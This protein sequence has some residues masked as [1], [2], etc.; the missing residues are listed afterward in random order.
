MNKPIICFEGPSGIGKTSLCQFLAH[1]YN[2]IP[3][4]NLLFERPE[5]ASKYWY[6]E[7]QVER[8]E[9]CRNSNFTSILDGD[10]FQPIWYNWVCDYPPEF[11]SKVETHDFYRSKLKE[12]S[13]AFPDLYIIFH[14]DEKELMLRKDKDK[15]RRRRNFEKH[16]RI[17]EPLKK[18][19][20]FLDHETEL[21]M[22]FVHYRDMNSAKNEVLSSIDSTEKSIVDG[23]R[24]FQQ[25]EN[26]I[27][28]NS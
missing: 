28:N 20:R 17:I 1:Q 9:R 13:I 5:N 22:T 21:K 3:E 8:F 25:I 27:N 26:W 15:T 6:H 10:I 19:Y 4:V 18:Y 23:V 16:L 11:L 2:I 24:I 12:G 7:R 14:V